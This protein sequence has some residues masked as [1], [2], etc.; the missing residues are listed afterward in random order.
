M[1][2][3]N[4]PLATDYSGVREYIGARY[5]PL[6]ANPVEW[7]DTRGYEPLTIV[8]HQGNS[9]TSTQFVPVGVD[10]NN[11]EYWAETGNWNAQIE[12]Y[13]K[14]VLAMQDK[15]DGN[16][17][18]INTVS[19]ALDDFKTEQNQTNETVNSAIESANNR[20]ETVN[21]ELSTS[22]TN[23]EEKK[24]VVFGDSWTEESNKWMTF[25]K[26]KG[27][28][29]WFKT[30]GVNG[31]TILN[32]SANLL[33]TQI[34]TARNDSTVDK[35]LIDEVIV[36]CGVNDYRTN[37][38]NPSEVGVKLKENL[39]TIQN[40]YPNAVVKYFLNC[41]IYGYPSNWLAPYISNAGSGGF[42]I[43]TFLNEMV[44]N[45]Y[46]FYDDN[47]HPNDTGCRYMVSKMLSMSDV[48]VLFEVNLINKNDFTVNNCVI[49]SVQATRLTNIARIRVNGSIEA[50]G[51]SYKLNAPYGPFFAKD[52]TWITHFGA[53]QWGIGT[54]GGVI[55]SGTNSETGGFYTEFFT[56]VI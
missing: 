20:I 14:E 47:L 21:N 56:K 51:G 15:V 46:A 52:I 19:K 39:N 30:Y 10:I 55:S 4:A 1:A 50:K 33:S 43:K 35:A 48:P 5:V 38:T 6:F 34:E 49:N 44:W 42:I 45:Q 11:K 41:Q 29:S 32:N 24:F 8:L 36:I 12:A 53:N 25:Y 3:N 2:E 17:E 16:T 28:F 31:A 23:I 7:T 40:L 22:I 37:K 26:E 27:H 9:F 13:R 18:G 54:D